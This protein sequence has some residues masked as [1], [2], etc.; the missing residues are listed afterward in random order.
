MMKPLYRSLTALLMA[1]VLDGLTKAWAEQ[2]LALYQPVPI[3]GQT[4]RL[5]LSYNTGVA[6][7][8]FANG[9]SWPLIVTGVIIIGLVVWLTKALR[10]GEL[11][12]WTGGP[13]GLLIGG[14][15]ANFADRLPDSRVT[16]FLDFGVGAWRWPTFNLA[17]TFIVL[18][19]VILILISFFETHPPEEER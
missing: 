6:F 5:T 4:L 1:L 19:V 8:L 9:G 11:P 12:V 17:D 14:A 15:I 7:G 13:M 16:D 18:G 3:I 2:T 10:S